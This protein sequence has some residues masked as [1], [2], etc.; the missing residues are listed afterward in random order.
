MR[1]KPHRT[2][3]LI[4]A[5][6]LLLLA[7][8]ATIAQEAPPG[9]ASAVAAEIENIIAIARTEAT[10]G[11]QGHEATA[12]ALELGGNAPSK[13][14]GGKQSGKGNSKGHLIDTEDTEFGRV[15]V[16]PWSADV[17][18]RSAVG[19]A[20]LARLKV[21]DA[22][23]I[24]V[25]QSESKATYDG[26]TSTGSSSSDGAVT[27]IGGEEGLTIVVL[28]AE[29][30]SEGKSASY[31]LAIN[32]NKIGTSEEANGACLVEV[33]SLVVINCLTA[34]GGEAG[35]PPTEL[36][37]TVLSAIVGGDEGLAAQVVNAT[38][39]GAA[40]A[41]AGAVEGRESDTLPATGAK[42]SAIG[43]VLLVLGVLAIRFRRE[44]LALS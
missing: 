14:F 13:E 44:I 37:A 2:L 36:Q 24:D 39:T 34:S 3:P 27:N 42:A 7:P 43:L 41:P 4:A 8:A 35:A 26:S 25:L 6:S 21:A 15:E 38:G 31:L 10:A 23:R 20:A 32:D 17:D 9:H 33:P 29:A 11:P 19:R 1:W 18:D 30:T 40:G 28:H 12:N 16:T 22:A 5:V